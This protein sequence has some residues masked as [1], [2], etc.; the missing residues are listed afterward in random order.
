MKISKLAYL[1]DESKALCFRSWEGAIIARSLTLGQ[2]YDLPDPDI[3]EASSNVFL[4][5]DEMTALFFE[6]GSSSQSAGEAASV[7]SDLSL[8]LARQANNHMIIITDCVDTK[9]MDFGSYIPA[10]IALKACIVGGW[11]PS[12][13]PQV[14]PLSGLYPESTVN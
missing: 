6:N 10:V 2:W 1:S 9:P 14:R 4:G 7:E 11:K 8:D 12:S 13:L 3:Q 5:E